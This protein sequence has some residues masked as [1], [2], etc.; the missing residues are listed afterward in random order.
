MIVKEW[1]DNISFR[2]VKPDFESSDLRFPELNLVIN[3]N[4]CR[5]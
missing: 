4:K 5:S 3:A 1:F 2:S